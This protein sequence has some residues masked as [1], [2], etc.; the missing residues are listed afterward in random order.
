M[1]RLWLSLILVLFIAGCG[2]HVPGQGDSWVGRDGQTL[3]VDLIAN[4]TAE[5]YLDN[6]VTASLVRQFSRSRLIELTEDRRHAD[7]VLSGIIFNFDGSPQ[8]YGRD[9]QITDYRVSMQ[10]AVRLSD[11]ASGEVLWQDELTRTETFF[12]SFDKN[13]QLEMQSRAA[14]EVAV[15]LAEDIH[16]HLLDTF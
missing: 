7:L 6:F 15:R 3:Y 11:R 1:K 16:A 10:V 2:Y 12:A 9:D 5:P 13:L 4:R 14:R 8:A